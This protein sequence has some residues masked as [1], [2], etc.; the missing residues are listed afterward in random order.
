MFRIVLGAFLLFVSV[1]DILAVLFTESALT[2][3]VV[4]VG[5]LAILGLLGALLIRSGR[6]A[7]KKIAVAESQAICTECGSWFHQAARKSFVI[8]FPSFA[9]PSCGKRF[10]Y[11]LTSGYRVLYWVM[12]SIFILSLICALSQGA[13][14]MVPGI[15]GIIGIIGIIALP[16]DAR[17]RARVARA[18]ANAPTKWKEEVESVP[19]LRTCGGCGSQYPKEAMWC[20]RCNSPL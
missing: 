1:V 10:L 3:R 13:T 12:A 11:P 18:E 9:C 17:I 15:P 5:V 8:G 14:L 19:E 16:M 6:K 20:P 7:R 2:K 4:G